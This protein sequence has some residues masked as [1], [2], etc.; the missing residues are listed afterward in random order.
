[1]TIESYERDDAFA[2]DNAP[3]SAKPVDAEPDVPDE[4]AAKIGGIGDENAPARSRAQSRRGN[5]ALIRRVAAKAKELA[6]APAAHRA[7][8][9]EL[10]GVRTD[11][12]E[13][14]VA[15]MTDDGASLRSVRSVRDL[16]TIR[17][18]M[19]ADP[20]SG[21]LAIAEL[22]RPGVRAVWSLLSTNGVDLPRTVPA[23]DAKAAI[24]MA[25]KVTD[26]DDGVLAELAAV[27]ELARR[28]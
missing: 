11:L 20:L 9:A 17:D 3:V 13:L 16:I 14:T 2:P 28:R 22:G 5:R 21:A 7:V 1:M 6:E 15:V 26:L 10:L 25:R 18:A 27:G 8:L 19:E 24:V 23:S 4:G 12:A